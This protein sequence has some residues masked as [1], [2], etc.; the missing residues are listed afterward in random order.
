ML[1]I[2]SF[3]KSFVN[4]VVTLCG[5]LDV[6]ICSAQAACLGRVVPKLTVAA[7]HMYYTCQSFGVAVREKDCSRRYGMAQSVDVAGYK[8]SAGGHCFYCGKTQPLMVCGKYG[9]VSRRVY[10]CYVGT[11]TCKEHTLTD[12]KVFCHINVFLKSIAGAS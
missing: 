2:I 6:E 3:C 4:V 5:V 11:R 1:R 12:S 10:R 9:D 7:E 8:R